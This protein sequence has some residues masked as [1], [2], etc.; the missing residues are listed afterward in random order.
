MMHRGSTLIFTILIAVYSSQ[1]ISQAQS[2]KVATTP[3][4]KTAAEKAPEAQE[5]IQLEKRYKSLET[6][7]RG[8]YFIES[9]YV[10]PDSVKTED[11]VFQ[12]LKGALGNLDP[13][14]TIMSPKSFKD[15]TS[16]AR[17]KFGGIGIIVSRENGKTIVV[18]PVEG[19]PAFDAGIKSGDEILA[20]DGKSLTQMES[21]ESLD[22][23]RGAPGSKIKITIRR[24]EVPR[25]MIFDLIRKVI[26]V[27][28]VRAEKLSNGN[29]YVR[30]ASFQEK[31][32]EDLRDK[33]NSVGS[34]L[35]GLILDLRDNPGGLLNQAVKV[36]DLFIESGIIV[37]T[38][39]RDKDRVEREYAHA[40]DTFKNFPIVILVNEGTASAS[41]I[42]AGALQDHEK[43][44]IV[45]TQTFGKGSVQTLISLPDGSGLKL[46]VARYYTPKDRSI[47]AKGITPDLIVPFRSMESPDPSTA[48]KA[49]SKDR[50]NR[51]GQTSERDLKRHLEARDLSTFEQKSVLS[52]EIK[53][54][55]KNLQSDNQVLTAYTYLKGSVFFT[56]DGAVKK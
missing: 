23:L 44:L 3:A 11:L 52:D 50:E 47:Q 45:G 37:S 12:S 27:D 55:P 53:S 33:L 17:G 46:T 28:S 41:E 6:L 48:E 36:S 4:P 20:I 26:K 30:V 5:M 24:R 22:M 40:K 15:M 29:L 31:T 25:E 39:G 19:T 51:R 35:K 13:H 32:A 54:W 7:A 38:V 1:L 49:E 10:D 34:D 21:T 18:S 8:L 16:D 56:K 14:S 9:M 42:V 43:A 2:N